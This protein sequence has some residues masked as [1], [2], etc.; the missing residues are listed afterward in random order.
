MWLLVPGQSDT[1][2]A[3]SWEPLNLT[4]G[5]PLAVRASRRLRA[6]DGLMTAYAATLGGRA[7][8]DRWE[9]ADVALVAVFRRNG[10]L[11]WR[12]VVLLQ[13]KRLYSNEINV[14]ELDDFDY[15]VGIGQLIDVTVWSS[16]C[17]RR[18]KCAIC[19]RPMDLAGFGTRT[20]S[21]HLQ[22][23]ATLDQPQMRTARSARSPDL[24][25]IAAKFHGAERSARSSASRLGD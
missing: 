15:M 14:S 1:H 23:Y 11:V 8:W 7:L 16:G 18:L 19:R 17:S 4:G 24:D 2:G 25:S 13:S 10:M 20:S 6:Q 21:A 5:D 3:A 12:K 9:I 22:L